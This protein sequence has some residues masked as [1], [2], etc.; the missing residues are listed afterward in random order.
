MAHFIQQQSE[1][2]PFIFLTS[3]LDSKSVQKAKETFPVGFLS[4]PIQYS[5]LIATI[6]IAM[7]NFNSQTRKDRIISLNN[8]I[9]NYCFPCSE[10]LFLEANSC[11]C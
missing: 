11:L 7:H 8:G 5:S 2:K 3:Q 10:I 6:E 9:K 1:P 4:K